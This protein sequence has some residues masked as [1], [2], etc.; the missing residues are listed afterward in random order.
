MQA[1]A[2]V[3]ASTSITVTDGLESDGQCQRSSAIAGWT[4]VLSANAATL[5]KAIRRNLGT[6]TLWR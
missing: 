6:R 4:L 1:L 2:T 3:E 5:M